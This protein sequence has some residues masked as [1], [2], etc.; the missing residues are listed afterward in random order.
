[1]LLHYSFTFSPGPGFL[2]SEVARWLDKPFLIFKFSCKY[3]EKEQETGFTKQIITENQTNS[4]CILINFHIKTL[5]CMEIAKVPAVEKNHMLS[6]V[7]SWSSFTSPKPGLSN[8]KYKI[9]CS[10]PEIQ[11]NSEAKFS[12][13]V[14]WHNLLGLQ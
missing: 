7:S 12:L 4:W 14:N 5:H 3:C 1:M 8:C 6:N 10:V 13:W 2:T 11:Q 9:K